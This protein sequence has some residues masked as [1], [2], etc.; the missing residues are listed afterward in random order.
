MQ[1]LITEHGDIFPFRPL[2]ELPSPEQ[3]ALCVAVLPATA[4]AW[5]L[6]HLRRPLVLA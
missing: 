4:V 1:Q 2:Q 6:P 5:D 3:A